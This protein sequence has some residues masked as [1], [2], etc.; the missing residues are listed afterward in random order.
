MKTSLRKNS[1]FTLL[2]IMLVVCIITLLIGMGVK[3]TFG[4]LE[5]AKIVRTRSDLEQL[6]TGLLMYGAASTSFPT[7]EQGL[8]A[9]VTKPDGAHN[10]R[11]QAEPSQL[12]DQW[13]KDFQYIQPG[14]HNPKSFDVFSCG[15]DGLPNTPDDIGNWESTTN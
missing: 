3:M 10:W 2:E 8:K 13:G 14:V 9:L 1:G 4:R 7:T 5:E 6:K 12:V 15:P 11:P